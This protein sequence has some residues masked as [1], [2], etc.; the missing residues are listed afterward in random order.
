ML[1]LERNGYTA[2]QVRAALHAPRRR[3]SFRYEL[4]DKAGAH[5]ADLS[6]VLGGSAEYN[7]LAE[8]KRTARF[9]LRDDGQ[10]DFLSDRIKP[11]A[12]LHMPPQPCVGG[13]ATFTRASEAR[14]PSDGLLVLADQPRFG[15]GLTGQAVM[16]EEGTTN[17]VPT[18]FESG[19]VSYIIG[20]AAGSTT[21]RQDSRYG[22]VMRLTKTDGGADRYGRRGA[23]SG[24]SGSIY[25]QS[26]SVR[27]LSATGRIAA[28]Y[29]DAGGSTGLITT[30]LFRNLADLPLGEWVRLDI[31]TNG[32]PNTLTGSGNAY[33][34]IDSAN[35]DCEFA[36]PQVELKSYRTSFIDGARAAE[37]LTIPTAGVLL[38]DEGTVEL[39]WTPQQPAS[40]ITSQATSPKILQIGDYYANN[41]L[42][43]WAYVSTPGAEPGLCFY[44][45]GST[46]TG[47]SAGPIVRPSGSGWYVPG[48]PIRFAV[49]WKGANTFYVAV[50]GT[51]YGPY[52][53]ADP[54]TGWAGGLVYLGTSQAQSYP[55]ALYDDIRISSRARTDA[56]IL[57]AVQGS[58]P[59]DEATTLHMSFDGSLDWLYYR[60]EDV[61]EFPLGVFIPSTPPRKADP[62]GVVT[63]E[64]EAYDLLQVLTDDKVPDRY[65]AAAG[66]NYITVVKALLDSAGIVAQNLTPTISTLP[67]DRDWDPGT[68][69]LRIVNDLLDAINYRSLWFDADGQ[70]V[71]Q[72]YVSP[73]DRAAEYTYQDDGQSVILPE[74]Q[75]S[76]DLFAV[77][78]R[79][80]LTV[81]EADRPALRSEYTNANVNSPTSTVSRGRTIVD[82]RQVEAADQAALDGM[83]Q[84]VAFE[85]SQVYQQVEFETAIMPMHSDS[86]V[87]NLKFGHLG[88]DAKYS[89]TGWSFDLKAGAR[90]R[91][92]VRRVVTV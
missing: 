31:A 74:V 88:L 64:V 1:N 38:P 65:T 44:V 55:N 61:M 81:S 68:P 57:A 79:W 6:N 28:M 87:L 76:L 59:V 52:T 36:L 11:H 29:V 66:T 18:D 22:K 72:P 73:A 10:V 85:A 54:L 19:W 83:T 32:S 20:T 56:E 77:P 63:R 26:I 67:A 78:N 2:D 71:A 82:Y 7:A 8:I 60:D 69:K 9:T 17:F 50:N 45:K 42:V 89:E 3:L 58:L 80:V 91:H 90:M 30:A 47:W 21:F 23:L 15:R 34:W 86:D 51:L 70:A 25:S 35:G 62:A 49:K 84:R 41:S 16:V 39:I 48:Q 24:M 40:G 12:R 43:L 4:L 46:N 13:A 75:E 92:R 14:R 37:S 5:K 33:I 53:V 27:A